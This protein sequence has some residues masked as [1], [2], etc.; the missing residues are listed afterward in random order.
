MSIIDTYKNVVIQIATPFSTGTGFYLNEANI[1][2][3]NNHVIKGNCE[4]V[5]EGV[6]FKKRIAKVIYTDSKYD[7]AFLQAPENVNL[8]EISMGDSSLISEG[9]TVMAI[10]HPFGLK[11]TFTQGI[12]SNPKHL[13]NDLEY[14]QH[15]AALNPGNSGGPLV[16]KEGAVIGVN[17]SIIANSNT[18]GFSLQSK[19]LLETLRDFLKGNEEEATR[20]FSCNNIVFASKVV[21]NY[22]PH[23]GS[24]VK[25]PS[26][27]D[28][29]NASGMSL[30]IE[31]MITKCGFDVR[32]TRRGP[33]SWELEN[34]TAT[35]TISYFQET[36]QIICDA[37]LALLPKDNIQNL[38]EFMLRENFKNEGMALSMKGQD[39]LLNLLMQDRYLNEEI[40]VQL[41]SNLIQK[42]DLYDNILI[43]KFGALKKV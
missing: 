20:C 23:C 33:M 2:V 11:Y 28:L 43:E 3:T 10:G 41:L 1:I 31:K 15:D 4:V 27:V 7:L 8:S 40:G 6:S 37:L 42:A 5:I 26:D 24:K 17:T 39:I 13:Q 29:Y 19:Y 9:D 16:N 18:I 14:I 12:V 34:G 36:G 32:L 25:L 22:C 30:T 35:I 38:Y 21:K